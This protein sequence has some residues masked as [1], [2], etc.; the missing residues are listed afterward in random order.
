ML[1]TTLEGYTRPIYMTSSSGC[2]WLRGGDCYWFLFGS[3]ATPR[4]AIPWC[5]LSQPSM[6]YLG[7]DVHFHSRCPGFNIFFLLWASMHVSQPMYHIRCAVATITQRQWRSM[8]AVKLT[9]K[10]FHFCW[11]TGFICYFDKQ[12]SPSWAMSCGFS[13]FLLCSSI[14]LWVKQGCSVWSASSL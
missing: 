7:L 3:H 8:E 5:F 4:C 6:L 1:L 10:L 13:S 2:P 11:V 9:R 14:F 12:H